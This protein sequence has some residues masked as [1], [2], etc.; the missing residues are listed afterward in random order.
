MKI[1]SRY[2]NLFIMPAKKHVVWFNEIGKE[3][4]A[5][6]GGKGAN[7]GEMYN[8]GI[9]VPNG[10]IVTSFAYFEFIRRTSLAN[11]I[12]TELRGLDTNNSKKLMRAAQNV[13]QAIIAAKMPTGT[14][15]RVLESY[16]QLS[17]KHD[18]EVA[19]RSS[20]TAE[21]LPEAS[22]AGQQKTFLDVKGEQNVLEKVQECW[23]S[24]F[25]PRAI[26]YRVDKGFD[27][28]EVGIAVPVQEMVPAEVSGIMF[29]V[30]PLSNNQHH[31]SIEAVY[32]LG[33][34]IVSGSITPDQYLVDKTTNQILTRHIAPQTWQLTRSG[35][36]SISRDYQKKQKLE[37]RYILEIAKLGQTLENH[38]QFPQDIEWAFSNKKVYI[39]QTRPITTLKIP[40]GVV[41]VL[42]QE[43]ARPLLEGL[44][45]SPGVSFGKVK[46]IKTAKEIGKVKD[47]DVLVTEMT[48]PDFVPAMRR[49]VAIVTDQGGRTSHAA[50]IS[51]E[52]G[53][54]CVV[55]TGSA[56]S[57]LKTGEGVTVNGGTGLVYEGDVRIKEDK[58]DSEVKEAAAD[59]QHRYLQASFVKTA[60]KV[61]VNLADPTQAE[62]LAGRMTD[63]VGL[64]RAEFM[65]AEVGTH[66]K[67]LLEDGKGKEFTDKLVEGMLS[68]CK[69]FYPRPVIYRATDFKTNEYASLEGGSLYEPQEN[70]PMLGYRGCYRYLLDSDI[71]E[72]EIKA[73]KRVRDKEGYKNLHLMIPFV[74]TVAQLKKVK[75]LVSSYGLTRRGSFNLWL[76]VEIPS[77]VIM[78]D[79]FL[80]V[81]VD[82][83]SVGTNDLTM[84]ILGVDRDNPKVASIYDERDPAVLW[85]LEK[86]VKTC[87]KHKVT[88]SICG[89][90]P[91]D[92]PDLVEKLVDWGIT[93]VSVNPD[94]VEK[95]RFIIAEAEKNLVSSKAQA[96]TK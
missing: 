14:A 9:P 8:L 49:A 26:F 13:Q 28:L 53:I 45:A 72:L 40:T 35:K 67:K 36:I 4:I 29:T 17:G 42:Q 20:A 21:D 32:G 92:Y 96:R 6:V 87:R 84:L 58:N 74:R 12:R 10:F 56:S 7:L 37:D 39:V 85:C 94:V 31:I 76:M 11:K 71:F 95:T 62:A 25:E 46:I 33:E 47:G 70:N 38:Y 24:L 82:G 65:I 51:R 68:F 79:E 54:P 80:E 57:M 5:Q 44:P 59:E 16:R 78:L 66:P 63:G 75:I 2:L 23:A 27:H 86:I 88:C 93:S 81:G 34:T 60:T 89:Q 1:L 43:G 15:R 18:I 19:V 64:L 73:I 50:I 48:T 83:V 69:A 90:A 55:G 91:S 77:N 41:E 22:F 52:L 30:D 3:D 61:Y